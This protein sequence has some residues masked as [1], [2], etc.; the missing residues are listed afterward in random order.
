MAIEDILAQIADANEEQVALLRKLNEPKPNPM[1]AAA[2]EWKRA[3]PLLAKHLGAQLPTLSE[4]QNT[5]LEA[6]ANYLN[7]KAD[8][9]DAEFVAQEFCDLYGNRL[10]QLN[11]AMQVF[12]TLGAH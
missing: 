10:L 1:A 11:A 5:L 6:A 8:S 4:A 2:Q 3:N 12:H 7:E 9:V